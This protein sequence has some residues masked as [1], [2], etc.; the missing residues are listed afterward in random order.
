MRDSGVW[1]GR[2]GS[3]SPPGAAANELPL[4][5][6]SECTVRGEVALV[7]TERERVE[8][9]DRGGRMCRAAELTLAHLL[10]PC[11]DVRSRR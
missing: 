6:G 7:H 10:P 11:S 3:G 2:G 5:C 4:L 9:A 1:W 8:C